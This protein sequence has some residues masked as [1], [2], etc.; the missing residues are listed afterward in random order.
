MSENSL[1]HSFLSTGALLSYLALTS[2][3]DLGASFFFPGGTCSLCAIMHWRT[4]VVLLRMLIDEFPSF[5]WDSDWWTTLLFLSLSPSTQCRG[6]GKVFVIPAF[7]SVSVNCMA[8]VFL[9]TWSSTLSLIC[10]LLC[11]VLRA[12]QVVHWSG[13]HPLP[14][15]YNSRRSKMQTSMKHNKGYV[16]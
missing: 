13:L 16:F 4:C 10:S 2:C 11:V 1:S 3:K 9:D 15:L 5:F 6:L 7:L 12:Q 8:G 14:Y